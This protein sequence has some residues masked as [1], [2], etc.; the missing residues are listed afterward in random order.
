MDERRN[1][2]VRHA[3]TSVGGF[4]RS[5]RAVAGDRVRVGRRAGVV[6]A[7]GVGAS[8]IGRCGNCGDAQSVFQSK[9]RVAFLTRY[10]V[11]GASGAIFGSQGF[12]PASGAVRFHAIS[13]IIAIFDQNVTAGAFLTNIWSFHKTSV[14]I[15]RL[16]T[17]GAVKRGCITHRPTGF[18][19]NDT[20]DG[21]LYAAPDCS[22]CRRR[23]F[24]RIKHGHGVG[25]DGFRRRGR[26]SDR[27]QDQQENLFHNSPPF[28][29]KRKTAIKRLGEF[30]NHIV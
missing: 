20:F 5:R 18:A 15:L 3:T 7:G 6:A 23:F 25:N 11:F 1:D 13:V 9:A 21:T 26:Q 10:S 29:D 30:I 4:C 2:S 27:A 19:V 16:V 22:R 12:V 8:G 28:P 24:C 17:Y 14:A